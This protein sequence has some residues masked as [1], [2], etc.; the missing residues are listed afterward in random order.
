M[1]IS[2]YQPEHR[3]AIVDLILSIQREEFGSAITL[4]D[5]PDLLNIPAVYQRGNGNFWVALDEDQVIGTIAAIDIGNQQL[6]L[7]K[8][9]VAAPYRGQAIG[10]GLQLLNTLCHWAIEREVRE[11]YLGTIEAFK[12]AHRFYEKHGFQRIDLKELPATFPVME[13]DTRFYRRALPPS[14][15]SHSPLTLH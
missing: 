13:L 7:R 6:A 1:Q 4:D 9:F 8:M 2:T 15:S 11:V 12:A 3:S 10:M 14:S 5:Q